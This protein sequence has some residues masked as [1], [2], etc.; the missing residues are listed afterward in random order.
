MTQTPQVAI[1]AVQSID[2]IGQPDWDACACPEDARLR[3]IDPFTTYR[4]L[5]ALEDSGSVGQ[6]T[7]WVPQYITVH[8]DGKLI[9][10]LPSFAKAIPKVNTSLITTGPMLMKI[11]GGGITPNF[12][13]PFH[14]HPYQGGVS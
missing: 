8:I 4:F 12:K 14:S 10:V 2:E 1:S 3:P 6:G 13:S 7:G 11:Q 5:K 9:G